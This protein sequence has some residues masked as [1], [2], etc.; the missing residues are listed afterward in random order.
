MGLATWLLDA[1]LYALAIPARGAIQVACGAIAEMAPV[2]AWA[3]GLIQMVEGQLF[4]TEMSAA[5]VVEQRRK[6]DDARIKS[7]IF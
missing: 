4:T 6:R 7:F 3:S 1:N 2:T 5:S